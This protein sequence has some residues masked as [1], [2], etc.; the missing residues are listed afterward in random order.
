M[1]TAIMTEPSVTLGDLEG[2]VPCAGSWGR[3]LSALGIWGGGADYPPALSP[4][5]RARTVPLRW[6]LDELGVKDC[7]W[8]VRALP[9][10]WDDAIV[11][12]LCGMAELAIRHT[13]DQSASE[14]VRI[15]RAYAR[16]EAAREDLDAAYGEAFDVLG[17]CVQEAV[18][19]ALAS[20]AWGAIEAIVREWIDRYASGPRYKSPSQ[21]S[22]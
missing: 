13:G 20:D 10:Q 8:A 22:K 14:V 6:V 21:R 5:D 1:S 12:L 18:A 17:Q 3:R 15:A 4:Q 16:G 19:H 9:S 2:H 7:L 11:L